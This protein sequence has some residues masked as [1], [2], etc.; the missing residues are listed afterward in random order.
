M[1][2]IGVVVTYNRKGLLLE[3]LRMLR[4]QSRQLNKV[5][6]IDNHST[7][8]TQELVCKE[9]KDCLNWIDYRY[10]AENYGGAGGFYYGVKFA[11][12]SG[13]D[14][15]W[16]MDDDGKPFKEDTF[17]MIMN[18]AEKLYIENHSLFLNSLVTFDGKNL[19]FGFWPTK[20][21]EQQLKKINDEKK[22]NILYGKAN[23][24]NGTLV[25]REVVGRIGYPR[26]EFFMSRDETD[27]LK[28]S[29]EAGAIIATVTDSVYCHPAS[30]LI[31]KKIGGYATQI[32][33]NLDKEYY[34]MRNLTYTYKGRNNIKI[35]GFVALRVITILLYENQ[36][37]KR[38]VQI[39]KAINDAKHERMGKRK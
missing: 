24:F 28:R 25:T 12:E 37:S 20:S 6:I 30:K 17:E 3:N 11:Y 26:K 33:D 29:Q 31:Y 27:Y 13:A 19:S 8:G 21:Q 10:M 32:Y 5:I 7:D 2:C 15:I 23:P 38:I 1:N 39:K 16:L 34:F 18:V 35:A 36:K 4:K 14:A 9:F 22:E